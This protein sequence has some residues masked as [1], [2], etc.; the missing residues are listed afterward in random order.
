MNEKRTPVELTD[1]QCELLKK[2]LEYQDYW[3]RIFKT[4]DGSVELHF[5]SNGKLRK[6]CYNS[7][8]KVK[9]DN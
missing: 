8:D 1:A 9:V 2:V 4:K 7:W 5:D 3:E 6:V